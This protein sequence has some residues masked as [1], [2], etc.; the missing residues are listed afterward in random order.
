MTKA[1]IAV[2]LTGNNVDAVKGIEPIIDFWEVRMDLIGPGWIGFVKNLTKPWVACNRSAS[3]GG[4]G[5]SDERA[6]LKELLK[7][8]EAGASIIDIE[9][10]SPN[11]GEA[12]LAVKKKADCLI[13]YHNYTET[14]SSEVLSEIV[15]RQRLLG[16][17]I[18][19]VVTTAHDFEDNLRLLKLIRQNADVP[20]VA[21]GMGEEGR[22]S[23]IL[24]PLAGAYFT[25]ASLQAGKESASGQ[26]PAAEM[27]KIYDLIQP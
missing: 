26:I 7:G 18:C 5:Q 14:P 4:E 17:D 6:R 20:V 1:R 16:A 13:S 10:S 2:A 25:F 19:K 9:L 3:E 11:L 15:K 24:S 12:V 8:L 23:R 21:F 22:I 27:R